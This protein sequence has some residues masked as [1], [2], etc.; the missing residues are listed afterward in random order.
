[1][2]VAARTAF[3]AALVLS[4]LPRLHHAVFELEGFER[5]TID[6][7]WITIGTPDGTGGVVD[8]ELPMLR[9]A[10]ASSGRSPCVT[11]ARR[12]GTHDAC[13][14][15]GLAVAVALSVWG[16]DNRQVWHKPQPTLARMLDAA[17]G[18]PLRG[19]GGV[20]ATARRCGIRPPEPCRTTLISTTT[21]RLRSRGRRWS[22]GARSST[23]SAP[24]ATALPAT[25]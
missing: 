16:C 23:A 12:G 3:L 25:A 7:F 15:S 5:T 10:L 2:L 14:L 20:R 11:R 6:R 24:P 19:D 9:D 17:E 13:A 22:R 8:G 18:R 4:G 21:R 1:M